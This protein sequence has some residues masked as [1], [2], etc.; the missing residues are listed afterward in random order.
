[1]YGIGSAQLFWF[2]L[3]QSFPVVILMYKC[4]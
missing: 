4:S 1:V 3:Q 2:C